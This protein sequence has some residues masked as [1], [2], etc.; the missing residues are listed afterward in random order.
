[1]VFELHHHFLNEHLKAHPRELLVYFLLLFL[2]AV[3]FEVV[4]VQNNV[5]G[6]ESCILGAAADE[7]I[8]YVSNA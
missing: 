1:M 8:F 3:G 5:V 2:P 4:A 7:K 6:G